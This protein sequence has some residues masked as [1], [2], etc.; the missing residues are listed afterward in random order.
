[1]ATGK[2]KPRYEDIK[3]VANGHV[4]E[5]YRYQKGVCVGHDGNGGGRRSK[6]EEKSEREEEIRKTSSRKARNE[7]RRQ[8]L[9]NF[10]ERSKFIT[11]TFRDGAVKDITDV[12]ECNKAFK[13]FIQRLRYK[14]KGFKYLAVIEFQ[15]KNDRGAVHYHMISD[16]PYIPNKDLTDI[17]RNGHVRIN[18]IRHVDN[19]G[20]YMVKYMLKDVNDERLKGNKAYLSS[21]GL[22]KSSVIRG[23]IVDKLILEQ[24]GITEDTKKAFE[25]SYTSEH[26]GE[27]QYTEYNLKRLN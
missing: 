5:V 23:D 4:L 7:V 24:Y 21:R 15:D 16:L 20:A 3:L 19:V 6:D 9:A 25:S 13:K 2:G 22:A 8:V 27:V 12:Q 17:W 1:M 10:T 11:L 14:Y 26:H 18:D